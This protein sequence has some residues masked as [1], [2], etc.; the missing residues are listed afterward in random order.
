MRSK[1]IA[2]V[3]A[4]GL[5]ASLLGIA[6]LTPAYSV[7]ESSGGVFVP[8]TP[9]RAAELTMGGGTTS[10]IQI[11]GNGRVPS[12][13]VSAVV[14]D[15]AV[16]SSTATSSYLTA[17]P[18]GTPRPLGTMSFNRDNAPRSNTAIV[19]LGA[20]TGNGGKIDVY[21]NSGISK[22]Y[23]DVQG[24]FTDTSDQNSNGGFVP[25]T[26]TRAMDSGHWV[27][28]QRHRPRTQRRQPRHS[29]HEW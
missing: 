21:N 8:V 13:G 5:V 25:I 7:G 6:N 11:R 4:M 28:H 24:Y 18:T 19:K 10:T 14:V 9:Y 22:V 16:T 26:P 27:R 29:G 2:S 17:W 1:T 3:A 12:T 23:V 15:I 20:G